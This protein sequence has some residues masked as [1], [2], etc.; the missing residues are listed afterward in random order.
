MTPLTR[1]LDRARADRKRIVFPEAT[2]PRILRAVARL[3]E[4]AI[5]EPVL[6]GDPDRVRSAARDA[7]VA[8]GDIETV[9][10]Q[11]DPRRP[12]CLAV[13]R[14]ALRRK[15]RLSSEI[16]ELLQRPQYYAAAMV[17][18]GSADGTVSGAVHPTSDTL[19]AALRIIG[20]APGVRTVSSF[21]LMELRHPTEA[22]DDV[23]AFADGG[24]APKPDSDDLAE[25]AA[26]TARHFELL[27]ERTPRVAFLSFSTK[28]SAKHAKVEKVRRALERFREREPERAADGELQVDAALIPEIGRMKAPGSPVAGRANVLIFPDLDA[29]NIGYKLVER[30]AGARAVG[31]ILQGLARPANDLS[32]GC[33]EQ[34][35]VLASA[36]TAVQATL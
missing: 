7:G 13:A 19:R 36:V 16:D 10:P 3:A 29:G 22:G 9:D 4:Q 34:D 32:R 14:E 21:F 33:D 30:L 27:V 2:D 23:L 24:L 11:H 5:V 18:A 1:I 26:W 12:E 25:I 31:P 8:L 35:I 17:R 28:G 6:L 20:P 15:I